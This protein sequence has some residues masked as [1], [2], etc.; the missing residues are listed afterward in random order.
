[1][2]HYHGGFELPAHN[3]LFSEGAGNEYT[4]YLL[5]PEDAEA[6][7]MTTEDML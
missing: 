5:K 1:M 2:N 4:R 7:P 6:R 3:I